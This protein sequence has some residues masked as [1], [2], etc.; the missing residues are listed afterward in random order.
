MAYVPILGRL[1]G[2]RLYSV[3]F[4][5]DYV[6]LW[7]DNDHSDRPMLNSYAWPA[8]IT[9][10]VRWTE[11]DLGWA[12]ALRSFI[13]QIV[14]ATREGDREGLV[15]ELPSGTLQINPT[16]DELDEIGPEIAELHGFAD[17]HWMAWRA[18]EESF[19]HLA[20]H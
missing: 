2:C 11:G 7:F 17:R 15:I 9:D 6:Q 18:G 5:M 8:V 19:E 10:G 20:R 1:V 14:I 4:V 3:Q 16:W 13:P 12:D